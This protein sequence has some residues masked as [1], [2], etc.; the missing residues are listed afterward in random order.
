MSATKKAKAPATAAPEVHTFKTNLGDKELTIEVGKLAKQ[1]NCAVTV[2]CGGTMVLVAATASKSPREGIDFFPLLV[3]V[4]QKM[5]AVGR[6]PGSF[7]RREGR[8]SESAILNS[9]LIDRGIRP[10]FPDGYRNDVQVTV[11]VLSSDKENQPDVL[12]I[13]GA[14]VALTLSSIPFAGPFAG[15]RVG[16][17]NGK[18]VLN[19]TYSQESESDI[20]LVVAGTN[21]AIMM[22]EAGMKEVPEAE[23]LEALELA[24]SA[25]RKLCEW[26]NKMHAVAGK[27]KLAVNVTGLAPELVAHVNKLGAKKLTEA[28]SNPDKL[29][30]QDA[31]EACKAALVEELL[32]LPES[33]AIGKL[34]AAA[35]KDA[36]K[37]VEH[38]EE[39]V[40][41]KL[42]TEKGIR[43]DGRKLDEIRPMYVETG[44]V[45]RAHGSGLFQRGQT[46]VCTVLT[47][48]SPG[49]AQKI[50]TIDP[51]VSRRYMHHYNFPGYSV[52]EVRPN[53]GAGRR[54]IGHGALAER[55]LKPVLPEAVEFPYTIR[56]VSEV[57]ESNGSSSMASTC[58]STL[59]ML[60][61]GVPLKRP[62]AGVAMGLIK[63][64]ER[65]AILTD[66][67]GIEDHLGDMDFKVTGT[68]RGI[69]ALQMDIKITGIEIEVMQVAL[70][71]ARKGRL[72]I[73]DV[74]NAVISA[75]GEMSPYAPRMATIKINPEYIGTLIGPGGKNIRKITEETQAKIDIDDTGL[76]TIMSSDG[77][78]MLKARQWVEK[79][80]REVEPGGIYLG[81]V[82]RILNFGAFV[83]LFPGKD[84][85]VH[86][87]QLAPQRVAKVEDEVNIGDEIIVKVVEVDAQGRVNLTRKGVTPEEA[88]SIQPQA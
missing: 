50:D 85:L 32:A 53:R 29:A 2:Q 1:A 49:D 56:L 64:G 84:G 7:M 66:I 42:V 19:P 82:V 38:L 15:V 14:G 20:D 88:A 18:W 5:Y 72:E 12:G 65:F 22:V 34:L 48:G 81:K 51:E 33:N 73:L 69:T 74:M 59:A 58:G 75:P 40:F 52:G 9:R 21:D 57:L 70:E 10:L 76:V 37:A 6:I 45:P 60:H 23:V 4:E 26:T 39:D 67:Q 47:L 36:K 71:Q 86:I 13:L 61:G 62:V 41:R 68:D 43:V 35:P 30:R 46:Q 16:R 11:T 54:E 77:A 44:L 80:T 25:I 78:M 79:H 55:A 87:S 24:H 27:A 31:I 8:A 28:M 83:E 3:D 63:E 17:V